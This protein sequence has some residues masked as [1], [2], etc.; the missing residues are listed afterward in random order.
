M[1]MFNKEPQTDAAILRR[2]DSAQRIKAKL[3]GTAGRSIN[4]ILDEA[5]GMTH[6]NEP[7]YFTT[8]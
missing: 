3:E 6:S 8:H 7:P 1:E 4:E 5:L 2:L